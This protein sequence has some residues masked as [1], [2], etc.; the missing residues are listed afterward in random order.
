[1]NN[2]NDL[3]QN[4]IMQGLSQSSKTKK[5]GKL[6]P[7]VTSSGGTKPVFTYADGRPYV[8]D[9]A[10]HQHY[11]DVQNP[12]QNTQTNNTVGPWA[13]IPNTS[14]NQVKGWE[15]PGWGANQINY[16]DM[17]PPYDPEKGHMPWS[18]ELQRKI[19][20]Q[21]MPMVA[22][23]KDQ[24]RPMPGMPTFSVT[25][26][27]ARRE[28]ISML[29]KAKEIS[30]D[31]DVLENT[32]SGIQ[33]YGAASFEGMPELD[34]V[35][36]NPAFNKSLDAYEQAIAKRQEKTRKKAS[37]RIAE[38]MAQRGV[39]GS[40]VE[41]DQQRKL[42]ENLAVERDAAMLERMYDLAREQQK[43][44]G[45]D[46]YR[47]SLFGQEEGRFE[48][49]N[50]IK[51]TIRQQLSKDDQI[52][53]IQ[54]VALGETQAQRDVDAYNKEMGL[55]DFYRFLDFEDKAV[56]LPRLQYETD[57]K[58]FV[59]YYSLMTGEAPQL[60]SR[61][62]YTTLTNQLASKERQNRRLIDQQ[63]EAQKNQL[64]MNAIKYGLGN[65][66]D[67]SSGIS[68]LYNLGGKGLDAAGNWIGSAYDYLTS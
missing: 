67:I 4:A 59:D 66:K 16:Q 6:P 63:G 26:D 9:T 53:R 1:M 51:D 29:A 61:G 25:P 42:E 62:D 54:Q 56:N 2:V 17:M 60:T 27:V 58:D 20:A 11:P 39:L 47:K 10:G 14:R 5:K 30:P 31:V 40:G 33:P 13:Y 23:L 65:Y 55:Q 43:V 19:Y 50:M 21:I 41:I 32:Y 46:A 48:Y 37:T 22:A 52:N 57:F 44:M 38:V 68:S 64:I 28:L 35:L 34:A 18:E 36:A 3:V 15:S 45:E 7:D 24:D 49:E 12:G 8:P